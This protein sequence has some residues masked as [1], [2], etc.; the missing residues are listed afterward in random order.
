VIAATMMLT[1][2]F[3]DLLTYMGITLALSSG[4]TVAG[5]FVLRRREPALS[6]PYRTW[7]HPFTTLL[8]LGLMAWMIVFTVGERPLTALFAAGTLIAGLALYLVVRPA[9]G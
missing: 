9:K 1:A 3:S 7:G 8:A 2:T 5:V 6:R 4:L